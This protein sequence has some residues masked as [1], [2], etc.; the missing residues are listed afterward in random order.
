MAILDL[1]DTDSPIPRIGQVS[2]LKLERLFLKKPRAK[3]TD[4]IQVIVTVKRDGTYGRHYNVEFLND[5]QPD[6]GIIGASIDI[7]GATEVLCRLNSYSAQLM[8]EVL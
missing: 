7:T 5:K 6:I 4:S 1:L 3:V 2:V 8:Y